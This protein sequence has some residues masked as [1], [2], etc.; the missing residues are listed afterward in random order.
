M[1]GEPVLTLHQVVNE[2]ANGI[3]QGIHTSIPA[4][5]ESY[6]YKKM[7]VNARPVI[8]TTFDDGKVVASPTIYNIP[9]LFPRSRKAAFTFPLEKGDAVLLVFS[10]RSLEE[11]IGKGGNVTPEDPRRHD[12]SDAIAIP[13][14]F[15]SGSGK[16]PENN[17]DLQ[18]QYEG[19]SINIKKNNSIEI[20]ANVNVIV[21]ALSVELG[22]P[23]VDPTDGCVTG[24]CSCAAYGVPHPMVS[25][26][27]KATMV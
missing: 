27:V 17:D 15:H 1:N 12:L 7:L 2:I 19:Q 14:M 9:V 16:Q 18:I 20:N 4:L 24:K 8:N 3:V 11:W 6:D 13:G 10:E 25:P 22:G 21:N 5:V 26:K 23:T